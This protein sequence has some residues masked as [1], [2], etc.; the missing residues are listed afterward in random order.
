MK[1]NKKFERPEMEVI[2]FN[3]DDV[4]VTSAQCPNDCSLICKG[5]CSEVT[6]R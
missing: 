5:D 6:S 4:I 3:A 1:I 2:R